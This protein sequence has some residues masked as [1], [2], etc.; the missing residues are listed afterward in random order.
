MAFLVIEGI[1]G[2]GKTTL[3]QSL[4]QEMQKNKIPVCKLLEPTKDSIW[5]I[6]VRSML[7]TLS[8]TNINKSLNEKMLMLY[9]QDRLWNLSNN[10]QPNIKNGINIIQ[11]RYF[12]STAAYQSQ[13]INMIDTIMND[14]L[15]NSEIIK[16]DIIIFLEINYKDSLNRIGQREESRQLFERDFFLKNIQDNYEYIYNNYKSKLNIIKINALDNKEN[17]LHSVY[18]K[19]IQIINKK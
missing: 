1:D 4:F 11:D 9:K 18:Q 3:V 12:L 17:I 6:E 14:Y 7:Q 10:I 15:S 8:T 16:P 2:C 5:G 13:D 19:I